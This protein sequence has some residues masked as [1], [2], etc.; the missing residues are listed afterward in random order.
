[1]QSITTKIFTYMYV[2]RLICLNA[3]Q[4][5]L[6]ALTVVVAQ[7]SSDNTA[8]CYVFWD[9]FDTGKLFWKPLLKETF[10]STF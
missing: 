5:F 9:P 6:Y 8:V 2:F 4:N 7:S 1:M 3:S 10:Q